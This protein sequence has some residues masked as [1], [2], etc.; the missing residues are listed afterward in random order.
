RLTTTQAL[1]P[2]AL[3]KMKCEVPGHEKDVKA[4]LDQLL[5]DANVIEEQVITIKD[6]LHDSINEAMGF[7]DLMNRQFEYK[8]NRLPA[9]MSEFSGTVVSNLNRAQDMAKKDMISGAKDLVRLA[10]E[11]RTQILAGSMAGALPAAWLFPPTSRPRA[12]RDFL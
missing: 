10:N 8:G 4:A 1:V 5:E 3:G 11:V 6:R 9:E 12:A 7:N 2:K